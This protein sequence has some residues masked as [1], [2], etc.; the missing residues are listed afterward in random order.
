ML[1]RL[2][3]PSMDAAFPDAEA[4]VDI[5]FENFEASPDHGNLAIDDSRI[6][7]G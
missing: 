2:V 4:N 1:L 3:P 5:F 7:D 6:R